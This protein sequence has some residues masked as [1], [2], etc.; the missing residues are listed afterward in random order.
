MSFLDNPR[1]RRFQLYR[2]DDVSGMSGTGI[3]AE[4][5]RFRDGKCAYRWTSTP[6]TT[7]IAPSIQD[8]RHIHGH[9]AKTIIR[10]MDERPPDLPDDFGTQI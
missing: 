2:K 3:V 10:W 7:Q 9:N 5:I 8:V 6:R 1:P 4:G